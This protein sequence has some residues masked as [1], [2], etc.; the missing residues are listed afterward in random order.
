MSQGTLPWQP[1][2]WQNRKLSSFVALAL[3]KGMEY[4]Y[5]NVRINSVNDASVSRENL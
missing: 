4:R 5:T 1:I 2:L 3:Q